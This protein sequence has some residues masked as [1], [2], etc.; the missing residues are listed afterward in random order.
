MARFLDMIDSPEDVKKLTLDQLPLLAREVRE[1]LIRVLSQTGGHLGPNLGVTELT[2]ALHR[3]FSC[4]K[5]RFVWDVSHQTYVHKLFTGRRA[6]F[7]KIRNTGGPMGFAYRFESPYDCYGAGHAGTALSAALGM[8]KARDLAGTD[9][10]II[11]I[12]GD[13]AL[14]N[15]ISYEALNNISATTT[16][17]IVILNHNERSLHKNVGAI[18]TYLNRITTNPNYNRLLKDVE[19]FV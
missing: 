8:C 5:D 12:V 19:E 15:G 17:F 2:I 4:P 1:E 13:A 11:A 6:S 7:S 9:E 10:H 14:T 16:K 3:I 18:S